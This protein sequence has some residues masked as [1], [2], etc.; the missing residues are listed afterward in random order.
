MRWAYVVY[1]TSK[2]NTTTYFHKTI[3][4]GRLKSSICFSFSSFIFIGVPKDSL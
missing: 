1:T 4:L 3:I 2:V